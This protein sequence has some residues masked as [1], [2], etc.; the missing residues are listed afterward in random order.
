M[1]GLVAHRPTWADTGL[2]PAGSDFGSGIWTSENGGRE[3]GL[4]D[5]APDSEKQ[6][7]VIG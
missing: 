5:A 1:G 3:Y 2:L 7:A 4:E 6:S